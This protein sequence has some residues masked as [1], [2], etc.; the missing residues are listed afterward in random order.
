MDGRFA[1][2]AW[3]RAGFDFYDFHAVIR[4]QFRSQRAGIL[5]RQ[6]GHAQT[7]EH[8]LPRCIITRITGRFGR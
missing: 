1:F 5:L 4:E 2:L 7:V 3:N 6:V 8:R